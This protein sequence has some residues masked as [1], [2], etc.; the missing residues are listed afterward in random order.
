MKGEYTM[1]TLKR[2]FAYLILFLLLVPVLST[3]LK[4]R[5]AVLNEFSYTTEDQQVIITDYNGHG[6][7]VHVPSEIYQVPVKIIAASAF[8]NDSNITD[9][10]LPETITEIRSLGLSGLDG[11]QT[12][13][14]TGDQ[15]Q[16]SA[17][18]LQNLPGNL[19][20]RYRIG[21]DGF[22]APEWKGYTAMPKAL[23]TLSGPT[24]YE[25]AVEISKRDHYRASTVIL[26]T[27]LDFPDALAG[28]PLA[29]LYD[30]PILLTHKDALSRSTQEEIE[31]LEAKNI[32]ILGGVSAISAEVENTLVSSGY[33][34][35][36]VAGENRF[37]TAVEIM[38][39]MPAKDTQNQAILASGMDYAD[40]L[41]ISS[42]AAMH[43]IPILLTNP[44]SLPSAT[45]AV[46]MKGGIEELIIVGGTVAVGSEVEAEISSLGI[47]VTR[48]SGGNRF[49]TA[50]AIAETYFSGTEEAF[51]GS[52]MNFPDALT[53]APYAASLNA[54]VLL[55]RNNDLPEAIKE[56]LSSGKYRH[57]TVLGGDIAISEGVK[58]VASIIVMISTLPETD[59]LTKEDA[60]DEL[61]D[62]PRCGNQN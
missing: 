40:A 26:A 38:E 62:T 13:E 32:M 47:D 59:E 35:T 11:L 58:D 24:R 57:L 4:A 43:E 18:S 1:C 39:L 12:L 51:L 22:T 53:A 34:V 31:R 9:L 3:S 41:S 28:G 45:K 56:E 49:S 46:L 37:A 36:R 54:P 5:G 8:E 30:A 21:A 52:G 25:T 10:I 29:F 48:V 27:A 16:L 61:P 17:L 2:S 55:T 33:S 42:Y 6:G 44:S 15:P 20:V 19:L 7:S 23:T 60:G 14:F 50:E